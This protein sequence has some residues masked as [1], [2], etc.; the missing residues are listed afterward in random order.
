[1]EGV[2]GALGITFVVLKILGYLTWSWW[3]DK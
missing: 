1:M 3:M 2:L